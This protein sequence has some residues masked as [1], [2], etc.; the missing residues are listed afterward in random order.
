MRSL[1]Q[2]LSHIQT[3]HHRS[4]D[5]GLERVA[6]VADR[7]G[8]R[9]VP[10]IAITIAG[11]NGK[12]SSVALLSQTLIHAGFRTGSYTSPHLVDFRER[13]QVDNAMIPEDA[14]C[15]A[16]N[17][18]DSAREE[19]T[20]TYFEFSTLAALWWF[21]TQQVEVA[22]LET[23]MGG[24][25]DAVNV[26]DADVA[27]ITNIDLD[28]AEWLGQDRESVA[29]EKAGIMRAHRPAVCSDPQP[30]QSLLDYAAEKNT[31]LYCLGR[32][33]TCQATGPGWQ[34]ESKEFSWC[35]L[36]WPSP[37]HS[38]QLHNAG[39]VLMVLA[40]LREKLPVTHSDVTAGLAAGV[41]AGRG[42]HYDGP[43]T[44]IFDVAHNPGAV[45]VLAERLQ[46]S[47]VK[48]ATHAVFAVLRDKP[49]A[50]IIRIIAPYVDA[51]Y[52]SDLKT[53]RAVAA[54]E[55]K[56]LVTATCPEADV[57]SRADPVT[58]FRA[59][60]RASKE[61]DR[62]CVFGSFYLVGD[63]LARREQLGF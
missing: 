7:L 20:L 45:R 60:L 49:V 61:D 50:E 54:S 36:P 63:I 57:T 52:L 13:I 51:W 58:A 16:F 56:A 59:A 47:P 22:V 8:L 55:L 37:M 25:L 31:P 4:V 29:L 15:R 3:V 24:R 46:R 30:P 41:P 34:W 35:D 26:I 53:E 48:G 23:G 1:S 44:V 17:E 39:G 21:R 11:T 12:G 9:P 33:Y 32:D 2:W 5:L 6:L 38:T 18:I 42:Q 19:V 14:L 43:P 28:H 62:I 27:L 40:L 10:H